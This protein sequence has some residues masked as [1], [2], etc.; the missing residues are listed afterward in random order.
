MLPNKRRGMHFSPMAWVKY[1][2][3]IFV[4]LTPGMGAPGAL[5]QAVNAEVHH[6]DLMD[7]S[8]SSH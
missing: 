8:H 4:P 2:R 5:Q 1:D 7:V 3:V 6:Q